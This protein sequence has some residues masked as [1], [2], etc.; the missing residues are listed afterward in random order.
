[1]R[2]LKLIFVLALAAAF[3]SCGSGKEK[4]SAEKKSTEAEVWTFLFDGTTTD[5]WRGYNKTTFPEQGWEIVDGTLHCIG[6]GRGEAGGEGGDII[7][8]FFNRKFE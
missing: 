8:D 4:K 3:V 1:M 7:Y 6:S 2:T 5:G